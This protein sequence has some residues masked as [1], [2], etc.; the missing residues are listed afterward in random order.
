[1]ASRKRV[2]SGRQRIGLTSLPEEL[3]EAIL[4]ESLA[5]ILHATFD[6]AITWTF[7]PSVEPL[8]VYK[9]NPW[10]HP[11]VVR[12]WQAYDEK[13][14]ARLEEGRNFKAVLDL[15][16]SSRQLRRI[17]V[18][19]IIKVCPVGVGKLRCIHYPA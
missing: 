12:A 10:S 15:A 9:L 11:S 18:H 4:T 19:V 16:H 1:M 7:D 3:L 13:V 8:P 6:F 5:D 17:V 14:L 2:T